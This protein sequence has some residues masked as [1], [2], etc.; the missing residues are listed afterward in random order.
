[1]LFFGLGYKITNEEKL[2]FLTNTESNLKKK[3]MVKFL[4][5]EEL[6]DYIQTNDSILN[7]MVLEEN[8]VV[9]FF[10]DIDIK[11]SEYFEKFNTKVLYELGNLLE[12]FI[13]FIYSY[14]SVEWLFIRKN[15]TINLKDLE[16]KKFFKLIVSNIALT[17][18]NSPEKYSFHCIFNNLLYETK[19]IKNIKNLLQDFKKS[20][21]FEPNLSS[22][23]DDQV[24]RK[25]TSLRF[26]YSK[27]VDSDYLHYPIKIENKNDKIIII[28]ETVNIDKEN[29][30]L[31]SFTFIDEEEEIY[32]LFKNRTDKYIDQNL[33]PLPIAGSSVD[34]TACNLEALL[35]LE[36]KVALNPYLNTYKIYNIIE[37][38]FKKTDLLKI[39]IVDYIKNREFF[40]SNTLLKEYYRKNIPI[41]FNYEKSI[42]FFCGKSEHKNI[43]DIS[44]YEAGISLIKRGGFSCKPLQI[45]YPPMKEYKICSFIATL[46]V[47]KK[48]STD[49]LI[50]YTKKNGW[51]L[52][53]TE[54]FEVKNMLNEYT[55]L[56]LKQD[57]EIMEKVT[58]AKI[59]D[60]LSSIL[61]SFDAVPT[62]FPYHFKFKNGILNT[63][64]DEFIETS[65]A[66]N[67]YITTGVNYD[68]IKP[69][70]YDDDLKARDAY[71]RKVID[72]IIPPVINNQENY[73][74]KTFEIN[75]STAILSD[76]KNVI[77]I[78]WG[79]HLAGKSTIKYLLKESIGFE[80]QL[81][82][83]INT[84]TETINLQ[85]PNSWLGQSNLKTLSVASES[86]KREKFKSQSFKILTEPFLT[87]K[88]LYSNKT[89]QVNYLTQIIDTNNYPLFDDED[90]AAY[91][92]MAIIEFKSYF[93]STFTDLGS[94]ISNIFE[95]NPNKYIEKTN[96]KSEI[97][98]GTYRLVFFNILKSWVQKYHLNG[99]K[100]VDTFEYS[101]ANKFE[102]CVGALSL[103]GHCVT[104]ENIIPEKQMFYKVS[105]TDINNQKLV[106]THAKKSY[107]HN[108]FANI[109]EENDW[110]LET[111][112]ALNRFKQRARTGIFYPLVLKED[113]LEKDLLSIVGKSEELI[114][115]DEK[116]AFDM[117]NYMKY[118]KEQTN[119]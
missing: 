103:P 8:Q 101:H 112:P 9:K 76:Y 31:Y 115:N 87:S 79:K 108:Y 51:K 110:Q 91:R 7:E 113:I 47:V 52:V 48:T 82:M 81:E 74:R 89:C 59:K 85:K 37:F 45:I 35:E 40:N 107:L 104:I 53:S 66:K 29:I 3:N 100:M 118:K 65:N 6:Y 56:F 86:A 28:N 70:D 111:L 88:K 60:D 54:F 105:I 34:L 14:E 15:E 4:T 94:T 109:V 44:I 36:D 95:K 41:E 18:S 98:K 92:R 25:K 78:F 24:F 64:N 77:T 58:S 61:V 46:D 21:V 11:Q 71:I 90:L 57:R 12:D 117:N 2:A 10:L 119:E 5:P 116:D 67:L 83:P 73:N 96:L 49:D 99:T 106:I 17:K 68:Y 32:F 13:F 23:I 102:K 62:Y 63:Q 1:M 22:F 80:N 30:G 26:I 33:K 27:K 50:I 39:E 55:N 84:Y 69:E 114:E 19:F 20:F 16:Y 42:C 93:K 38:I 72:E 97:L 75:I 43:F